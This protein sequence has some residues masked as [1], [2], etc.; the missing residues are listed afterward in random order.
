MPPGFAP[1][2]RAQARSRVGSCGADERGRLQPTART[3]ASARLKRAGLL[4]AMAVVAVNIWTGSP[5]LAL[6]IGSRVQGTGGLKMGAVFAVIA[7]MVVTSLLLIRLLGALGQAHDRLAGIRPAQRRQ[8]PWMRSLS[9]ERASSERRRARVSALDVVLVGTVLLAAAAFEVWFFFFSGASIYRGAHTEVLV[10]G[11]GV[12][13]VAA[14][15]AA[16]ERGAAVV[17]SEETDWLGGQLTSQAV[18]PDEHPWIERFGCTARYRRFRDGVREHY[19]AHYPLTAAAR[20]RPHLNPGAARVS[21]LAHEPKVALA[22]IEAML[23]AG[24]RGPAPPRAG[25]GRADGDRVRAVTLRGPRGDVVVTADWVIDATET[26]ELLPLCGAEHVTG[27]E[28][29]EQT[30][31]P[32]APARADPLTCSR[33]RRAS[34]ST[35]SR[36]RTTRSPGPRATRSSPAFSLLAP[37]PRTG[38]PVAAHAAPQPARR[39]GTRRPRPR[40]SRGRP[41]PVAVPPH[42]RPRQLRA[43]RLP[44]RRHARELAA[45]RLHRRAGVRRARRGAPP[46]GR[47]P[48]QPVA[49][50][51]A[52]G[53]LAGPAPARRRGR[54]HA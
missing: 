31:E 39:P 20:A 25:R 5:L 46:R 38:R 17:L 47:A 13:G 24:R 30:G 15:L 45:G 32:H 12:G 48:A 1:P 51:L 52:A 53:H 21:A 43:G 9:G 8:Q 33:S 35:T 11:G 44:Q 3:T 42:P 54:R 19:R 41:R 40:R 18:P 22:V 6:W 28:S 7:T 29:R 23:A 50:A 36:A 2:T 26:G 27:S 34:R 37:D 49:P 4:A 16:A 10:V 14:A